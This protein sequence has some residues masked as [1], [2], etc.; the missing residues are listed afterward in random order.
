MKARGLVAVDTLERRADA[1]VSPMPV[2]SF[3][4]AECGSGLGV[5]DAALVGFVVRVSRLS[6]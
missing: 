3:G 4:R 6:S 2:P 5:A 1:L